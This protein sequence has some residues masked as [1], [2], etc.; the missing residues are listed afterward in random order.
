MRRRD[1]GAYELASDENRGR[2]SRRRGVMAKEFTF[3][4]WRMAVLEMALWRAYY[5]RNVPWE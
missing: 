5:D 3:D 4:P 1:E 2:V